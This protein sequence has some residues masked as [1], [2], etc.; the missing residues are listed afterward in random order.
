MTTIVLQV[1]GM[2]CGG[3]VKSIKNALAAREGIGATEADLEKA[4]VKIE[5][6]PDKIQETAIRSTITAAG[7]EVVD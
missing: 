6:D 1:S 7:F 5:F 2:T 3:C 4:T